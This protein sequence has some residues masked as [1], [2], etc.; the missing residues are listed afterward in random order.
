MIGR[1]IKQLREE[2]EWSQEYLASLMGYK[3]K[4]SINKIEMGINDIPQSKV[5]QFA[6]VF[7]ISPAEL[8]MDTERTPNETELAS[9]VQILE[10]VQ[11]RYGKQAVQMLEIFIKLNADGMKRAIETIEPLIEISRFRKE[12]DQ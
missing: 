4:S 2:R 1:K 9:E 8:L 6:Q 7:D 3:S 12:D 10:E 11:K 5:L